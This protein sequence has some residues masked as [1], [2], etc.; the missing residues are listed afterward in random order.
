MKPQYF[1]GLA[2]LTFALSGCADG[3][4]ASA[5]VDAGDA[6]AENS[7]CP[8]MG[9]KVDGSTTVDW[10]GKTIG[11]CC[12][13]CIDEWKEMTDE[14][15]TAA[16]AKAA[17]EGGHSDHGDHAEPAETAAPAAEEAAAEAPAAAEEAAAPAE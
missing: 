3:G 6:V 7:T 13:P 1:L 10:N 16:L 8:C 17:D 15:R 14:E 4:G 2:A 5:T 12:P 9:G 11:F